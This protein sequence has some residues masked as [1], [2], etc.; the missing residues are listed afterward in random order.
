MF[1][2]NIVPL[3]SEVCAV[4]EFLTGRS[5]SAGE[6]PGA[7]GVC[8]RKLILSLL[9][10]C[11]GKLALLT[12]GDGVFKKKLGLCEIT[13]EIGSCSRSSGRH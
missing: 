9:A 10:L 8:L 2:L 1:G 11:D 5:P 4:W 13:L 12:L 6:W 3:G 7:E